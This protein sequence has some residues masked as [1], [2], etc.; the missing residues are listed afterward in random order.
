METEVKL[1]HKT[2]KPIKR[3]IK[4]VT[5][6]VNRVEYFDDRFYKCTLPLKTPAE[7]IDKI[8]RQYLYKTDNSL[9]VY[10]PS[11][12]TIINNTVKKDFLEHWRGTVGNEE[13]D[14]II[15]VALYQGSVIHEAIDHYAHGGVVVFRTP[16]ITDKMIKELKKTTKM[17]VF[18]ITEQAHMVQVA[19]YQR[20]VELLKPTIVSSEQSLLSLTYGCA[21]TRDQ[22]WK[23][24]EPRNVQVSRNN[25]VAV[26]PGYYTVD[27]KTGKTFSDIDYYTQVA[28]YSKMEEEENNIKVNGSIILHLN[29]DIKTGIEGSKVYQMSAEQN[30]E[31]FR[32]F[33]KLKEIFD[34]H[35]QDIT[36][37]VYDF[38]EIIYRN[39]EIL[40]ADAQEINNNAN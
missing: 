10:L 24:D 14:R 12:T 34:F 11:V 29:A 25:F 23:F 8:P 20:I 17:N 35:K 26:E 3:K 32:H 39:L 9:D 30:E 1:K 13:A 21:G 22:L 5:I 6:H 4:K 7:L 38:P 40:S 2:H 33:L 27:F 37:V 18:Q 28:T 19:R 16:D 15:K 31:Y 36:P